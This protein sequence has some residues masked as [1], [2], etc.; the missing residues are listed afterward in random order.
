MELLEYYYN[1]PYIS[2]NYVTRKCQLPPIIDIN[3]FGVRGSGKTAMVLDLIIQED[4][5]TTLYIDMQDPN[6]IFTSLTPLALQQYIDKHHIKL[7]VLDH[8]EYTSLVSFPN[9]DRLIVLSRI[10]L[11]NQ[12]QRKK[13]AGNGQAFVQ[14]NQ[15]A[16]HKVFDIIEPYLGMGIF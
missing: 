6:L 13:L 4:P 8:Y 1:Q 3:L 5:E 15:G 16:L 7:L 9:V 2:D 11:Q 14:K 12:Q 10:L